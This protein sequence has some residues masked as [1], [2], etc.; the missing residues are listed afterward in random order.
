MLPNVEKYSKAIPIVIGISLFVLIGVLMHNT[1]KIESSKSYRNNNTSS[2]SNFPNFKHYENP[3]LAKV[4]NNL[5]DDSDLRSS[6]DVNN[7]SEYNINILSLRNKTAKQLKNVLGNPISNDRDGKWNDI[8]FMRRGGIG[9]INIS[10]YNNATVMVDVK[11]NN[12]NSLDMAKRVLG[13]KMLGSPDESFPMGWRWYYLGKYE[14]NIYQNKIRD[15]NPESAKVLFI[16][17]EQW[18]KWT[19]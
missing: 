1:D 18:D 8:I 7:D 3:D 17:H 12:I 15:T 2:E 16:S 9:E 13:L 5:E 19:R 6:D 10:L 11:F 4:N 14:V